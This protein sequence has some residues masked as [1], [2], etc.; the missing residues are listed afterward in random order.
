MNF[1]DY[2]ISVEK[3]MAKYETEREALSVWALGVAGEAG[4]VVDLIKKHV[5]M[6]HELDREKLANE[7]ADVMWYVTALA[8]EIGFSLEEIARMNVAKLQKRY[9]SG[10]SFADSIARKDE[11][12]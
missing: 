3:N 6:G 11:T 12:K 4:E 5:G 2:Q 9:P 1:A 7:L 8:D 10:F